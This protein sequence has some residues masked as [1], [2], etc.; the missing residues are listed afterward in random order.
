MTQQKTFS[1]VLVAHNVPATLANSAAEI[2]AKDDGNKPNLGRT[3]EDQKIIHQAW[4][5][6]SKPTRKE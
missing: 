6:L 5:Y 1:E 3:G 2:L 4:L